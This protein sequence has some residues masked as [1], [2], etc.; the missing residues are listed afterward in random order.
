VTLQFAKMS[1]AGNDFIVIDDR[2][3]SVGEDARELAKQLCR[4]RLS[5]GADGL[6]LVTPSSRCDFRMRY[7][8]ADGSEADMCGNGG[9]CV[10]RFAHER[11]IAGDK[12]CFESS[13]GNHEASIIDDADVRLAMTDPRALL[14][15]FE[16]GIKGEQIAVHRVNTGVP[17]A[18]REVEH[19]KD[20]P[21]VDVGRAIREH[22][23]FM[24]DGTNVDFVELDGPN[25]VSLRT[26]ERGVEDE[27][28]ACGT[29][30]VAS[31]VVMAALGKVEPPVSIHT[32]AGYTLA[33]DFFMSDLG[34]CDVSLTGDARTVYEGEIRQ[35]E[36]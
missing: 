21:V 7:F 31:A 8:N 23:K 32:K 3:N 19:L 10:A 15:S 13:S 35:S 16:I 18:V 22:R 27:T 28:L 25:S 17:H 14:L 1:G 4:R 12:M 2:E 20:Y 5:V 36:D 30:A 6:I 24:P 26:Y 9:R 33:V 29:G 11:D 34:F